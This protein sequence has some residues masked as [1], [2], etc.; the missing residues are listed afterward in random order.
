[1][2]V[3]SPFLFAAG[4]A[5][6]ADTARIDNIFAPLTD[7]KSPGIAVMVR[8]NG[9]TIVQRGFGVRDLR[10]LTP[11][12]AKTNFRLASCTKQFTAMAI[13]L[14]VNDGKLRYSE[15]LTEIFSD[16]PEYGRTITVRHLLTHTGGLPDYEDLMEGGPWTESRQIQDDEALA[17]LK[18]QSKPKFA[19]GTK[20]DYSN[21]G[22]VVLG[23]VVAK[24]SGIPFE[25]FLRRRIFTPLH[26]DR[27]LA[28]RKGKNEVGNRAFGHS[29]HD[30][31][32]D[33]SSSSA[34]LGDGG[35]Y[36]NLEDL[37]K[38][39]EA[40]NKYTLLPE[41]KMKPA[42]SAGQLADGTEVGYGFGWFLEAYNSRPRMWHYG[43]TRG[44]STAIQR[45]PT[46]KLTVVVLCN[47]TDLDAAKL[48]LQVVDSM[49]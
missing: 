42:W 8:K 31:E 20:W 22:Y 19:A 47:R 35:V 15:P 23:L 9:E 21:S 4:I 30:V 46:D 24:V 10:T 44:F 17:L 6:A 11:I 40:L 41:A 26:M 25:E 48:A 12:D 29:K 37:A 3:L 7:A 2:K 27:T 43:S 14:L 18:K 38:W 13:M 32:T 45:F 5:M 33:Q 36:S 34:T 49:R 16:F 1:M 28:Y 39:D